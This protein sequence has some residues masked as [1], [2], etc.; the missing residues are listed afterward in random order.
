MRYLP[1]VSA[2]ILL[3]AVASFQ[4]LNRFIARDEGYYLY[5]ARDVLSGRSVTPI[6][7]NRSSDESCRS[8]SV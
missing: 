6:Q 1:A 8:A 5:A 4:A 3:S 7:T 2:F